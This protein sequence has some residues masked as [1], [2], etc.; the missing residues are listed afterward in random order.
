MD[1]Y[2]VASFSTPR[3]SSLTPAI[4]MVNILSARCVLVTGAT[5]G[6]GRAL[7]LAIHELQ[8]KPTVIVVGRRQE[9][10]D[11]LAKL[12]DRIKPVQFDV[13]SGREALKQFAADMV[14]RFPEVSSLMCISCAWNR[15]TPLHVKPAGRDRALC[16]NAECHRF[17]G[18]REDRCRP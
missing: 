13:A 15:L 8:T 16:R 2:L 4:T 10:L 11:E 14:S 12:S 6:I 3:H 18:A 7:A 17:H 9:R 1:I 5:S